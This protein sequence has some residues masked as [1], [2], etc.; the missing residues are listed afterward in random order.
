MKDN[1]NN[2]VI[3]KLKDK[4]NSLPNKWMCSSE[5]EK[6]FFHKYQEG[7]YDQEYEEGKRCFEICGKSSDNAWELYGYDEHEWAAE[8]GGRFI[9]I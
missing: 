9:K 6:L 7:R 2:N 4:T 8:P 5:P 1:E 3:G